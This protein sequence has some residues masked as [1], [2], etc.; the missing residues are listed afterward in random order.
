MDVHVRLLASLR[1]LEFE[2]STVAAC[3]PVLVHVRW[4]LHSLQ[5]QLPWLELE[6]SSVEVVHV[7]WLESLSW[8]EFEALTVAACLLV[9]VHVRWLLHWLQGQLPWL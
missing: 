5:G 2:A 9:L 8:L 6:V 3:L 1:W 7:C 4:L